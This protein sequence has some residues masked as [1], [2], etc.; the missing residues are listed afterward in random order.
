[1][2]SLWQGKR[3]T[4]VAW[5]HCRLAAEVCLIDGACSVILLQIFGSEAIVLENCFKP[6]FYGCWDGHRIWPS[7]FGPDFDLMYFFTSL[8][9]KCRCLKRRGRLFLLEQNQ[10]AYYSV[11]R[12]SFYRLLAWSWAE[13]REN[14]VYMRMTWTNSNWGISIF[15]GQRCESASGQK[16]KC[17]CRLVYNSTH[18]W[19]LE[20][21]WIWAENSHQ[22]PDVSWTGLWCA[23]CS[24]LCFESNPSMTGA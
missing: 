4:S 5:Q 24:G 22:R 13:D 7:W 17:K 14:I 3:G 11:H 23:C 15:L 12:S 21:V 6:T 10:N 20:R 2:V 18:I 19:T 1:M 8:F 9:S 16:L